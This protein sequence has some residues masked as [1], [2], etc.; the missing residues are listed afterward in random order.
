[1]ML[2]RQLFVQNVYKK[3]D[4]NISALQQAWLFCK[5]T[6]IIHSFVVVVVEGI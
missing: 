4:R 6:V 3:S 5:V 1:M 2:Q